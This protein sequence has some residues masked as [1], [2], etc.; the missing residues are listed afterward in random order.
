LCQYSF[1]KKLQCQTVTREKLQKHF[2]TKKAAHKMLAKLTS[3]VDINNIFGCSSEVLKTICY[4]F[5]GQISLNNASTYG[6]PTNILHLK[7]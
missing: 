7:I 3:G 5:S 6:V 4:A 2:L 1:D